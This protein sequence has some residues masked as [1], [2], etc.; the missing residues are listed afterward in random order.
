MEIQLRPT[1]STKEEKAHRGEPAELIFRTEPEWAYVVR[2]AL[3]A[4]GVTPQETIVPKQDEEDADKAED[5][6]ARYAQGGKKP[7]EEK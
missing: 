3:R 6:F 4:A 7:G 2:E 1:Y 5:F